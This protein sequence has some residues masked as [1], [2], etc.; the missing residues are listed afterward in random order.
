MEG[1]SQYIN[2]KML[3]A[4]W[5][6]CAFFPN[7]AH[8]PHCKWSWG[9]KMHKGFKENKRFIIKLLV[10]DCHGM[11][12]FWLKNMTVCWLTLQLEVPLW[13][14][15]LPLFDQQQPYLASKFIF[16]EHSIS[17]FFNFGKSCSSLMMWY[18]MGVKTI[19]VVAIQ[20]PLT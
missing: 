17:I 2:T 4:W 10:T 8:T 13:R 14:K 7:K 16:K 5:I 11:P 3:H 20:L 15:W 12:L 6:W 9:H 19:N 18:V 1:L